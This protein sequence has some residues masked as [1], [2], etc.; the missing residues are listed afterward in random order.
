MKGVHY[1]ARIYKVTSE[2]INRTIVEIAC[3]EADIA[4]L[5]TCEEDLTKVCDNFTRFDAGSTAVTS[6]GKVYMLFEEQGWV[7]L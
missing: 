6:E 4:N 3:D 7:E 2:G 5:P 1:M